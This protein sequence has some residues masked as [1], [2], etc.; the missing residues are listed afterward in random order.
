MSRKAQHVD[1]ERHHRVDVFH[2]QH[3]VAKPER[4]GAKTGN[5]TAGKERRIVDLGAVKGF[6]AIARGIAKRNQPLTRLSS[7]SVRGLGR[8]LDLVPFQP[9]RERIQRRRIGDL[10]A[11]E[12]FA[13][14]QRPVDDDALLAVVHP[15]RQQRIASARPP[16]GRPARCRTA[17]SRRDRMNRTRH[18]P[19]LAMPS[20][21]SVRFR[22]S[23]SEGPR[24]RSI[25]TACFR[26]RVT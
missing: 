21:V 8:D 3:G 5:R 24:T 20:R 11:E 26:T 18:I 15:E 6:E 7:A 25:L 23:I 17:A 16:A 1:I 4:A 14:G 2:R 22:T 19:G 12:A 13:F 9:G 10:P